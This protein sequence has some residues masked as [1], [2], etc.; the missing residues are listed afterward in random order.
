MGARGRSQVGVRTR[1]R[2]LASSHT[3][4]EADNIVN[5][6]IFIDV[7]LLFITITSIIIVV[8]VNVAVVALAGRDGT[9]PRSL[10][11]GRKGF[12][13]VRATFFGIGTASAYTFVN[14]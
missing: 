13:V 1:S 7:K 8:V 4:D 9:G 6:A 12:N 10:E 2:R 5:V 14:K 3:T 11:H